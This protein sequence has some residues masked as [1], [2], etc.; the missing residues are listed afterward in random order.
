METRL[1]PDAGFQ[2]R[3]IEIGPLKNVSL[4]TRLRTPIGPRGH[5]HP[6]LAALTAVVLV[7]GIAWAATGPA[8]AGW[9][10]MVSHLL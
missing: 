4:L 1:V 9:T 10:A 8:H 5:A 2:L 6:R 7:G 3:L